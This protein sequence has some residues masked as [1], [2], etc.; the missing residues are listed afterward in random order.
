MNW[1]DGRLFLAVARAGQMLGAARTLGINQATLGRRMTSL[2]TTLGV[3]LLIRRTTGCD[4]T[5][6]GRRL[7]RALEGAEGAFSVAQELTDAPDAGPS[8]TVRI[9]APDGFG[10]MFLAPRLGEIRDRFPRLSI[11]LVPIP[12]SFSLSQRE[13][14][15]AVMIERPTQGRL[16]A[17]KLTDYSLSLYASSSY[18]ERMG[19]PQTT[20][21]L[22]DHALIG[23]VDDLLYAPAL[24][25]GGEFFAG[26]KNTIEVS[27]AV[28]QM[29]AVSGGAGIG[30]LHDYLADGS[31]G[32]ELALPDKL[33]TRSYWTV[34]HESQRSLPR[35]SAV[36]NLIHEMVRR[37][38]KDFV[39]RP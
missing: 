10:A 12:R 21:D 33:V 30:I 17:R 16:F 2:E 18:L 25:Y 26:W 8:G 31:A 19:R 37:S 38:G 36:V 20:S 39:R 24:D 3:R 11:Q 23:Y 15:V 22:A 35:I 29:A 14:D 13:A 28:G 4:L 32:L 1:D 6:E 27:T 34:V 5:D 9:G 7:M